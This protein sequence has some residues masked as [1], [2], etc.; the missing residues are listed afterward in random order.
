M[1]KANLQYRKK[2]SRKQYV[3]MINSHSTCIVLFFKFLCVFTELK[4]PYYGDTSS[5]PSRIPIF[6]E[7]KENL[8]DMK[9]MTAAFTCV[10]NF[11]KN[12]LSDCNEMPLLLVTPLNDISQKTIYVIRELMFDMPMYLWSEKL[13]PKGVYR[14]S[15]AAIIITE[16]AS[17]FSVEVYDKELV[18]LCSRKCLTYVLIL[19]DGFKDLEFFEDRA[20]YLIKLLWKKRIANVIIAGY[21]GP[22]FYFAKSSSF[23]SNTLCEPIKPDMM[24]SCPQVQRDSSK[25][26][27]RQIDSNKCILNTAYFDYQPYV[28]IDRDSGHISGME[29]GILKAVCSTLNVQCNMT[30]I[31]WNYSTNYEDEVEK[32]LLYGGGFDLIFGGLSWN[33]FNDTDYTAPYDVK[34]FFFKFYVGKHFFFF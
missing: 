30:E 24:M 25:K 17:K 33:P 1:M 28:I 5:I 21:V 2:F 19:T 8:E 13:D 31:P 18:Y 26:L 3:R 20:D 27:L 10:K 7:I 15:L 22:E 9:N 32:R 4:F 23:E 16:N 34:F 6:R 11:L 12:E 29:T 14:S